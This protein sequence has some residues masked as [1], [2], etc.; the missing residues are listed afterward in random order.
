MDAD[1]TVLDNSDYQVRR[2]RA[3]L[4]Y[5]RESW[6]DWVRE[7][8]ALLLPGAGR[9]VGEVRALGGL[10]FI[11]T[12]REDAVCR[13]TADN[14]AALGIRAAAVLCRAPGEEGKEG[15]FRAVEAGRAAPGVGPVIVLAWIG[16][17]IRDFP[18]MAQEMRREDASSFDR[19]GTRYFIVP[20]PM[21]G[22]W[23]SNP[24]RMH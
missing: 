15:R 24:P 16:D 14:L 23:E 22:S 6:N 13:P 20:N 19:F 5:T 2:A 3:G 10:V 18:G 17:N 21:Y 11:V 1:E 9:F 8:A 7:E 4:G 12:N